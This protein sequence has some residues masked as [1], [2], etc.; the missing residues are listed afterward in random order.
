MKNFLVIISLVTLLVGCTKSEQCRSAKIG[1]E[2]METLYG[3]EHT[4]RS[5]GIDLKDNHSIIRSQAQF[6][7][8]VTGSC[9]DE[10]D[11]EKYDLIIGKKQLSSGVEK[12]DYDYSRDCNGKY[13]LNVKIKMNLTSEAPNITFHAL[14]PKLGAAETVI[15]TVEANH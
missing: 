9:A 2:S 14:V 15:V 8:L 12:I 13:T 4:E 10:L 3:C 6:D 1:T 5:L 7:D 11:F